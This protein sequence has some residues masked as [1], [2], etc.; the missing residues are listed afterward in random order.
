MGLYLSDRLFRRDCCATDSQCKNRRHC[1]RRTRQCLNKMEPPE[2]LG[3]ATCA[4]G[5]HTSSNRTIMASPDGSG[6]AC[7]EEAV[8]TQVATA[9]RPGGVNPPPPGNFSDLFSDEEPDMCSE[10]I[11]LGL[12]GGG[13]ATDKEFAF[14]VAGP[15]LVRLLHV[16]I[17]DT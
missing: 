10:V 15:M 4:T 17:V 12:D 2:T 3:L 9:T 16:A 6:S 11:T 13:Y 7:M 14:T 1:G 8:V 5:Y